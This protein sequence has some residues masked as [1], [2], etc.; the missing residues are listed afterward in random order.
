MSQEQLDLETVL[1]DVDLPLRRT[2]YPLGFPLQLET[3]SRQVMEAASECWSEFAPTFTETAVKI[4]LE[5]SEREALLLQP[6][7]R[8]R[9]RGHLLSIFA[10][11]DNFV[12]CDFSQRFAFGSVTRT[13]A[14][15]HPLL[16]YRFLHPT[17]SML[18]EQLALAPVHG[19]LIVRNGCGV[20]LC[21]DSLAGKSTLSYACSRAGWTYVTDDAS[22]L[23]R[24]RS[25][26]YAIGDSHTLRLRE[27]ALRFFPE[28][29]DQMAVVRP[30]GKV[31]IEIFTR[32]L[33]IQ[34]ALGAAVEHIVFLD[35]QESCGVRL[36]PYPKC[37]AQ[38]EFESHVLFGNSDVRAAQKGCYQ[39]L[40]SA[41]LW[42]MQ[43]ADLED[44][45]VRLDQLA[46]TGC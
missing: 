23:L 7:S 3:N 13:V 41:D 12:M 46:G 19:A 24:D 39:Q 27:D 2:F 42:E 1:T 11:P 28:L 9:S 36:R 14:C 4:C 8:F 29:A 45:V 40:L 16:R 35:R 10:D 38:A 32:E 6:K 5:V 22:H 20:L 18:L 26:R 33:P 15:D 34:T 37:Q 43:Y 30:N 44:A 21:G 25:D 31:A 17:A